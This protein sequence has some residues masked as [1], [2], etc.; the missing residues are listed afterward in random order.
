MKTNHLRRRGY[1][2]VGRGVEEERKH[3]VG[4]VPYDYR[5]T[6]FNVG[7]YVLLLPGSFIFA[8]DILS[9]SLVALLCQGRHNVINNES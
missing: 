1:S 8:V 4:R 6:A 9:K 7:L 3:G 5:R 2:I